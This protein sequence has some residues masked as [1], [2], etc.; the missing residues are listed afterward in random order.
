M[1]RTAATAAPRFVAKPSTPPILAKALAKKSLQAAPS[2]LPAEHAHNPKRRK[3][4]GAN[5]PSVAQE[6]KRG[7]SCC[8]GGPPM[9]NQPERRKTRS[10]SGP[11]S[12]RS[13]CKLHG[14]EID[15]AEPSHH[16]RGIFTVDRL[17]QRRRAPDAEGNETWEYLVRWAGYDSNEDT[18]QGEADF[19]H[20]RVIEDFLRSEMLANDS[21][22]GMSAASSALPGRSASMPYSASRPVPPRP[23]PRPKGRAPKAKVWCYERGVWIADPNVAAAPRTMAVE[24]AVHTTPG[25]LLDAADG[26]HVAAEPGVL[27]GC[28]DADDELRVQVC[29]PRASEVMVAEESEEE[30]D[31]EEDDKE[32]EENVADRDSDEREEMASSSLGVGDDGGVHVPSR[33]SQSH[34]SDEEEEGG[35]DGT[36]D[37]KEAAVPDDRSER[38]TR[39]IAGSLF[40]WALSSKSPE[41]GAARPCDAVRLLPCTP[42]WSAIASAAAGRDVPPVTPPP[43]QWQCE[44]T[45]RTT[46]T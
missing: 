27:T 16:R 44:P 42:H 39:S 5:E 45:A 12:L 3:T 4:G 19:T 10:S 25:S 33:V 26:M 31:D 2:Q 37:N 36:A 29:A 43:R 28:E 14:D 38:P 35:L 9:A 32:D 34:E 15:E 22:S 30:D 13:P 8:N 7:N 11:L 1:R 46:G 6:P 40:D 21:P 24:C 18:W 17:I 23:R 41:I 20:R